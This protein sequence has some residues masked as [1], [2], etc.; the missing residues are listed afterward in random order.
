MSCKTRID[1]QACLN[2]V[3]SK[4]ELDKGS[5]AM[6]PIEGQKNL[7]HTPSKC[8]PNLVMFY[9]SWIFFSL[10]DFCSHRMLNRVPCTVNVIK[11]LYEQ[12]NLLKNKHFF[13]K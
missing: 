13:S 12:K 7:P 2:M 10:S 1:P 8:N 4:T 6:V 9:M 3:T 5:A 11:N